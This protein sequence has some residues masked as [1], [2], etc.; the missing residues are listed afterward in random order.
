MSLPSQLVEQRPDV[1]Q[2]V[3]NLHAA[4]A[5]IGIAVASRLPIINLTARH[6][7]HGA[8]GQP[9]FSCGAGFWTLA[10]A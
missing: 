8:G 5:Q 1:R 3:E 10:G 4:S 9:D 7:H 2:A 6:R